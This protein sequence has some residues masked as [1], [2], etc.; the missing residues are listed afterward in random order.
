MFDNKTSFKC[1]E[2]AKGNGFDHFLVAYLS[3]TLYIKFC[4]PIT[5]MDGYL[6]FFLRTRPEF[7]LKICCL[8]IFSFAIKKK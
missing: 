3:N 2:V 8:F 5:A 1:C 6:N 4:N 7:L